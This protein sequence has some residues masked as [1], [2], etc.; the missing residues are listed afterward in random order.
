MSI[1][2]KTIEQHFIFLEWLNTLKEIDFFQIWPEEKH[3]TFY[4]KE[5]NEK[6]INHLY[7]KYELYKFNGSL[8]WNSLSENN[9]IILIEYYNFNFKKK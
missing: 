7:V 6:K 8:F 9:Q 2:I 5:K 4:I 3:T 1:N